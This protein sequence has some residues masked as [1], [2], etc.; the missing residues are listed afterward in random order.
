[1]FSRLLLLTLTLLLA[2]P[3]PASARDDLLGL[4]DILAS[5][6]QH[7]PPLLAAWLEQD[8]AAGKVRR[9]EGAFDPIISAALMTRPQNYYTASNGQFMVTQPLRDSG[10]KVYAGYRLTSG[11]LP[12]YERKI[13]TADGGEAVVGFSLPFLRNRDFDGRRASLSQAELDRELARPNI[14]RQYLNFMRASRI[15]YFNWVAAGKELEAA[16]ALLKVAKDRDDALRQQL[17]EGAIAAIVRTDNRRLVVAREIGVVR[18]RRAFEAASIALSL[19]HREARTGTTMMPRREQLPDG[20]PPLQLLD[21]LTLVNDRGRALFRRPEIRQVEIFVAKA[22]VDRRLAQNDL[23]P[24]LDLTVELN[25]ALGGDLPKDIENT[26]ITALMEFS[27]PI[28][29]NEAKGRIEAI[30][31]NLGQLT[32]EKEFARDSILADANDSF[33]AVTAAYL[34]LEQTTENVRL[35]EILENAEKEKFNE[36]ASD[37]LAVQ[38]REQATFDARILEINALRDYFRA[39]ADY[40]A[41]VAKDSPTHLIPVSR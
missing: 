34:T 38:I 12:S 15:S 8:I 16:E 28:G 1:M 5:V 29:R 23:K 32:K 24:N 31:A 39:L 37:L 9:A 35:S 22:K 21:E 41:A 30:N 11:F 7:Y 10:G 17:E 2:S 36:G 33:S 26:E 25:Q 19:F 40:F 27:V 14:L 13:R 18:A 4:E 6:R 20:F 3:P